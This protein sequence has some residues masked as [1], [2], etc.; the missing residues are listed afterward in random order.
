MFVCFTSFI[1]PKASYDKT[2]HPSIFL[3]RAK[4][5]LSTQKMVCITRGC[6]LLVFFFAKQYIRGTHSPKSV[7]LACLSHSYYLMLFDTQPQVM[8]TPNAIQRRTSRHSNPGRRTGFCRRWTAAAELGKGLL[9]SARGGRF[10]PLLREGW[11]VANEMSRM[12]LV[13]AKVWNA[14]RFSFITKISRGNQR[15][16][17]V[18]FMIS[19]SMQQTK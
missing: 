16:T 18:F 4:M 7:V 14:L 19:I 11:G 9:N 17:P 1:K 13:V 3:V 10:T 8:L 6:P 15:K 12:F 5:V 2:H